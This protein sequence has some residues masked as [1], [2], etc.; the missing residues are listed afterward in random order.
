MR[1]KNG[2]TK[3]KTDFIVWLVNNFGSSIRFMNYSSI[4][5]E[6][7]KSHTLTERY[8]KFWEGKG[9]V[10]ITRISK[11]RSNFVIDREKVME[12]ETRM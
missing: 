1:S 10:K 7:G 3:P 8:M 6:Y 11:N 5:R 9:Y 2:M 4:A 12:L